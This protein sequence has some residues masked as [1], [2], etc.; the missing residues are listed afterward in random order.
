[1]WW[2]ILSILVTILQ[3][4]NGII[5]PG[6][7]PKVQPS[8]NFSS[9]WEFA[10]IVVYIAPFTKTESNLYQ[11]IPNDYL[12]MPKGCDRI[13]ISM[14]DNYFHLGPNGINKIWNVLANIIKIPNSDKIRLFSQIYNES[15]EILC[16]KPLN[17]SV[18][19]WFADEDYIILWSCHEVQID[20]K[21]FHDA[22]LIYGID[23]YNGENN[24]IFNDMVGKFRTLANEF[25]KN[26]VDDLVKWPKQLPVNK[27]HKCPM[28]GKFKC[29]PVR[30]P[31]SFGYLIGFV[32]FIVILLIILV[33]LKED[34]AWK[35]C[36]SNK[37]YPL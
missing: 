29:P 7:C 11:K 10:F 5:L 15:N 27:P 9:S 37:I 14:M 34:L 21:T 19:V 20:N 16:V 24:T 23:S 25:F 12:L 32:V 18:T 8:T 1:M 3:F 30:R 22:A 13:V 31:S 33:V 28:K 26:T 35:L 6:H 4:I 36:R 2:I 17:E